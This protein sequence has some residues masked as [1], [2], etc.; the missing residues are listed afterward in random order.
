MYTRMKSHA[1]RSVIAF[2]ARSVVQHVLI[3]FIRTTFIL[4]F[5]M[6]QTGPKGV[7]QVTQVVYRSKCRVNQ[8]I[9]RYLSAQNLFVLTL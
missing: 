7:S 5:Q 1:P 6:F 4:S 9:S 8:R 3:V 2:M